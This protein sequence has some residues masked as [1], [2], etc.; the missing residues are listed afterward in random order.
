MD[1][2]QE[3]TKFA[4]HI[5]ND[6]IMDI[7]DIIQALIDQNQSIDFVE[8]EFRRNKKEHGYGFFECINVGVALQLRSITGFKCFIP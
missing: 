7:E 8:S 4:K 6:A 5:P 3:S 2:Y 1:F